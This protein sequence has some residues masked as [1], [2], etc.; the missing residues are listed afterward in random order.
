M[1][2]DKT[3]LIYYDESY[4]EAVAEIETLAR[5]YGGR[6]RQ[7]RLWMDSI[8][9]YHEHLKFEAGKANVGAEA[10]EVVGKLLNILKE[11]RENIL[12]NCN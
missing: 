11:D 5:G 12:K 9:K 3:N 1:T 7:W 10:V 6:W 8:E 4:V 2:P